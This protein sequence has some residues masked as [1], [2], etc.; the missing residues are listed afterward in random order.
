[1]PVPAFSADN[2]TPESALID[3][4]QYADHAAAQAV[5]EPMRGTAPALAAEID[6]QK[7]LRLRCQFAGPKTERASWDRRVSLNLTSCRGLQFKVRCRDASPVSHFSIYFQSGEGWYHATFFPESPSAWNVITIDKAA[8]GTEGKPAGWGQIR[9]IRISAWRGKDADTEFFL[10]DIRKVGVL[11]ADASVAIVRGESVARRSPE[12]ARSVEQFADTIAQNLGALDIGCAVV[13]DL[14][15]TVEQLRQAKLVV[16]PHNPEMPDAAAD[17]LIKYANR[18]GKLLAFY[19]VPEKLRSVL[20]VE[21][22]KHV[23]APRPGAFATIRF[24]DKALAGAPATVGQQSWNINA[25]QPMPGASRVLAEWLDDQGRPSGYAAVIG[26][27][28]SM[29]MTHVLLPGDLENKRR[30]L[31]AMV[32]ALVPEVWQQAAAAGIARIGNLGGFQTFDEAAASLAQLSRNNPRVTPALATARGLRETAVKLALDQKFAE[33]LEQSAEASLRAKEA[34]CAAQQP[35]PGEFRAFWCHSA[36]GVEGIEWDE[37]IRRLADNGFTAILPNML[38]GGAAFYESKVLPSAPTVAARGDQIAKCL[39]AC[40]KYGM[41]IHVWKVNWNLGHAAPREFLERMR[42]EARLQVS[43]RGTEEPWLCPSHPAN[44]KLEIESMVEVAHNYDV[45]GIHFDYIRYPDGD[46]CFCAGCKQRFQRAAAVKIASWPKD[47][48]A[49][50]PLRPR[51]LEWRRSNITTVVKAVSEQARA[52]KP[53]IKISAAVFRNWAADRDGVGQDW[54]L[55]CDN[56]YLDF[57][58]RWTTRRATAALKTWSR[59]K[60]NGRAGRPA[61]LGSA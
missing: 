2:A 16:L 58:C 60:S 6:G 35:L 56:G 18:G 10:S 44:Q 14:D 12:E 55:W 41:Q 52:L 21:G 42:R 50:G 39:A 61:I 24:A 5:W 31:L 59:S 48:L 25:V 32:G 9:T 22:G 46:H 45:D 1:M 3:S 40:R 30:M 11:G 7:S 51:W 43:S 26:S 34:F 57:V 38:W 20:K 4:C 17:E 33:S 8:T 49:D 28:N 47:V 36:F 53:K 29:V 19:T 23:K 54:K 27:A 37:A 15:I 13:S